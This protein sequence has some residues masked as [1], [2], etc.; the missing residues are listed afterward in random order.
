MAPIG[1]TAIITSAVWRVVEYAPVSQLRAKSS[2]R[3]RCETPSSWSYS[4][5]SH[6]NVLKMRVPVLGTN[7]NDSTR[8]KGRVFCNPAYIALR[9]PRGVGLSAAQSRTSSRPTN[10]IAANATRAI[11]QTEPIIRRLQRRNKS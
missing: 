3:K 4:N 11:G 5:T 1:Q 8:V 7:T 2:C 6:R 9:F 10:P